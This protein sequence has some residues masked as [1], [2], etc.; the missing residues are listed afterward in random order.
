M[1]NPTPSFFRSVLST[2]PEDAQALAESARVLGT[3]FDS[4]NIKAE[5]YFFRDPWTQRQ[6]LNV[7]AGPEDPAVRLV[8]SRGWEESDEDGNPFRIDIS[9]APAEENGTR[10]FSSLGYLSL[11]EPCNGLRAVATLVAVLDYAAQSAYSVRHA[12]YPEND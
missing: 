9:H 11:A 5:A 3:F 7:S 2:L 4:T 8:L 6:V 12:L 10:A 1:S